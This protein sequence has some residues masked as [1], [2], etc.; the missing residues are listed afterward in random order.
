MHP[1]RPAGTQTQSWGDRKWNDRNKPGRR[2]D[3]HQ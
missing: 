1:W 2:T 3:L